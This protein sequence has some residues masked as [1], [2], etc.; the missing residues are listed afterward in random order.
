MT[1]M[2]CECVV[3]SNPPSTVQFMLADRVVPSTALQV[4]GSI[5]TGTLEANLQL[6]TALITCLANNTQGAISHDIR[7]DCKAL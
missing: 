5:T 3:D 4:R 1:T 6:H 7:I 2:K